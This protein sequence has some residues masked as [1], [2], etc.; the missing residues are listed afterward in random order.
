MKQYHTGQEAR[1]KIES[2]LNQDFILIQGSK[3]SQKLQISPGG[4]QKHLRVGFAQKEPIKKEEEFSH[5]R[6]CE[7]PAEL[8]Q[9]RRNSISPNPDK[10]FVHGFFCCFQDS[11]IELLAVESLKKEIGRRRYGPEK[12]ML[13]NCRKTGEAAGEDNE[14]QKFINGGSGLE[15]SPN[16]AQMFL[17]STRC[18]RIKLAQKEIRIKQE[19]SCQRKPSQLEVLEGKKFQKIKLQDYLQ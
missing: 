8:Q 5:R 12:I 2:E 10:L 11:K 13:Q 14:L 6:S 3:N 19:S 1:Q 15:K 7:I 4:C 17:R 18:S 16:S 9:L